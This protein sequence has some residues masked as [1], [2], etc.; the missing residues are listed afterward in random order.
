[1]HVEIISQVKK[2]YEADCYSITLPSAE[3]EITVLEGHENL[4][5]LLDVGAI[6][7]RKKE[8]KE[9][10]IL[11]NGGMVHISNNN[12]KILVNDAAVPEQIKRQEIENAMINAK[13]QIAS[14]PGTKELIQLEKQLRFEMFKKNFL[15]EK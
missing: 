15:D 9:E 8:Q 6:T 13:E 3:G 1:M 4:V 7:I 2:F 14:H 5:T 10:I 12:L 11:I